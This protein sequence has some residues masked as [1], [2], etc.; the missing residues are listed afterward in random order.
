MLLYRRSGQLK[1]TGSGKDYYTYA[2]VEERLPVK[3]VATAGVGDGIPFPHLP[4]HPRLHWHLRGRRRI[5]GLEVR[6]YAPFKK[7]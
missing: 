7:T 2:G 3:H 4:Q 6:L 1:S 5:A